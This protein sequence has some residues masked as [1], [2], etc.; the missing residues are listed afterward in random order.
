MSICYIVHSHSGNTKGIAERCKAIV[1]GDLVEV[2]DKASYNM[3]TLYII[4]GR[5]ATKGERDPI[6]PAVIDVSG[7]DGIVVGTPVWGRMPT[8]A[9]NAAVDALKGCEEKKAVVYATC[10]GMAGETVSVL[11]KALEGRG[12][13]VQ[14]GV[15]FTRRDLADQAK[16]QELVGLIRTISG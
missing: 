11:S 1:G 3:L 7:Y 4:G 16:L 2:K 12:A 9:T 13:R 15:V 5:R 6:D 14:G 8:P 10:G